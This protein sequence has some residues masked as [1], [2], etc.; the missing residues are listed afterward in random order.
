VV[1]HVVPTREDHAGSAKAE[2]RQLTDLPQAY[3]K[4]HLFDDLADTTDGRMQRGE[5][6]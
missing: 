4:E 3:E 2:K 1:A 5:Y 6:S